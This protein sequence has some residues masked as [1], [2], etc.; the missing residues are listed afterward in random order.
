MPI[1]VDLEPLGM[2]H[3]WLETLRAKHAPPPDQPTCAVIERMVAMVQGGRLSREAFRELA[4]RESPQ[5]AA[6]MIRRIDREA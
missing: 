3:R 2:Y 1:W 6:A 4:F 5:E